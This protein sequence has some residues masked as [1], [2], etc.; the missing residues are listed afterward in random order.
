M[1]TKLG[2][3]TARAVFS[4]KESPR[5]A[6]KFNRSHPSFG[7]RIQTGRVR[8]KFDGFRS[9]RPHHLTE[10]DAELRIA[11]VDEVA[12]SIE[13]APVVHGHVP[14]DLHHPRF[15]RVRRNTGYAHIATP[16]LDEEENVVCDQPCRCEDLRSEEVARREDVFVHLDELGPRNGRLSPRRRRDTVA[17]QDVADGLVG[18]V[19]PEV[20]Q[21]ADN[22]IV[23]PTCF[24][25][26]RLE[27]QPLDCDVNS[28]AAPLLSILGTVELLSNQTPIPAEDRLRPL[29]RSLAHRLRC[30]CT[31]GT[32]VQS[33]VS[34]LWNCLARPPTAWRILKKP[35]SYFSFS[36]RMRSRRSSVSA[37]SA[38]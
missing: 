32:T 8:R 24:R 7:E 13:E 5:Q 30:T 27:N 34:V 26:G 4:E 18:D 16:D 1:R 6:F 33:R 17:L 9:S 37:A 3:D 19:V 25:L 14:N 2:Q 22:P 23:S 29:S 12:L 10:G 35:N 20:S 38:L 28:R 11:I 31:T 21:G 36:S 15:V